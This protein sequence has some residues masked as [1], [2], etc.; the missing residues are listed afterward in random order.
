LSGFALAASLSLVRLALAEAKIKALKLIEPLGP[1]A[2]PLR[3][4]DLL[5][6]ALQREL[7]CDGRI[8]A[9]KLWCRSP[10]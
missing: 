1:M 9:S 8:S 5:H 6:P 7:K 4:L 2:I 3:T 10:S